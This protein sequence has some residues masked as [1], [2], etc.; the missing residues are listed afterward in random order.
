MDRGFRDRDFLETK[1]GFLSC[2]VGC[3]HPP[4]KVI[5]YIKYVPHPRGKWGS[6]EKRYARFLA[7]YSIPSLSE[8]LRFLRERYPHY[9]FYSHEW[10]TSMSCTPT[11]YIKVH[12]RPEER[13]KE[14]AR[15]G[16]RDPLEEETIALARFISRESGVP[17]G[18][19]GVTGS[20]LTRIHRVE[21]SDIDLTVYGG[22]ES[23]RVKETLQS[24]YKEGGEIQPLKGSRL[25][26]WCREKARI[27]PVTV[28]E[29]YKIYGRRWNYGV[30]KGRIF[31]IHP[32]R[33]RVEDRYGD[34]VF[35]PLGIVE[36][37]AKIL[38]SS[39]AIFLPCTYKVGDVKVMDG[40][41]FEGIR[42]I[43]SYEGFYGDIADPGDRVVARGR[44]E[45]VRDLR[46]EEE[47]YRV[48]IG[49]LDAEGGDYIK[50]L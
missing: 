11:K 47:Y 38:D 17:L 24:L 9:I 43:T 48:L 50:P 34:R 13:L 7:T 4:D 6:G 35:E 14:L 42:E 33:D 10:N 45:R 28:E 21:F 15:S 36:V 3:I 5:S 30:F 1:E 44:L 37:S 20:I 19:M 31:S 26:D 22:G 39:E 25:E 23:L 49:S 41:R 46:G 12:Y 40:P 16:E 32:V 29:A 2:V 18:R 8:N 27:Y